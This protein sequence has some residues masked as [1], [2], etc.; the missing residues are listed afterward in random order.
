[1]FDA[2]GQ[3]VLTTKGRVLDLS[4][5]PAGIYFLKVNASGTIGTTRV[6]VKE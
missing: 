3:L 4:N 5:Q 6:I 2:C 1:V